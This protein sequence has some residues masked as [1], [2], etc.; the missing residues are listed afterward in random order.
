M[1]RICGNVT[2][3]THTLSRRVAFN[4]DVPVTLV[5]TEDTYYLKLKYVVLYRNGTENLSLARLQAQH[6]ALNACY[7][8]AND[9]VSHVPQ[10]GRYNFQGVVGKANIVFLPSDHTAVKEEDVQRIAVSQTF[11]GLGNVLAFLSSNQVT[12][13]AKTLHI[14]C[15]PLNSILGE[16]YLESNVCTVESG[17]VG[18]ETELGTLATFRLGRTAVH[19][20]G[21]CLGLPHVFTGDCTQVFSDIPTQVNPNFEFKLVNEGGAWSGQLCNRDRDCKYYR[22]NDTSV[23]IS[24]VNPPYSCMGCTGPSCNQCDTSLYEQGCNFLDYSEDEHMV[25]FSLQQCDHMRQVLVS[26]STGMELQAS[27]GGTITGTTATDGTTTSAD[28]P[29]TAAAKPKSKTLS[30]PLLIGII[31]GSVVGAVLLALLIYWS[32]THS[33]RT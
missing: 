24:G 9:N 20:V 17:S 14:I 22:N 3:A 25:M 11:D 2:S 28:V 32:V 27:D 16:A 26:G 15:A 18:G 4:R 21:H 6:Q 23:L 1:P 8:A 7:N 5:R 12:L 19:E 30:L 29:S 33:K 10:S 13:D 31:V